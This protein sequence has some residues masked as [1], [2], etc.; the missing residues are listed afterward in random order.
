MQTALSC[1]P[2]IDLYRP[3][4]PMVSVSHR[5]CPL[6][7]KLHSRLY[8]RCTILKTYNPLPQSTLLIHVE[9][10]LSSTHYMDLDSCTPYISRRLYKDPVET[11][12][13]L[14]SRYTIP[15]TYKRLHHPMGS[16]TC[17]PHYRAPAVWI[18]TAPY[19]RAAYLTHRLCTNQ[20][21]F[22]RG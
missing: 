15:K 20:R 7:L 13:T 9:T 18:Y 1:I 4:A 2:S 5:L 14:Y 17:K 21:D 3:R 16:L 8:S 11:H 6:P 10:A 22:R 19:Q 12:S